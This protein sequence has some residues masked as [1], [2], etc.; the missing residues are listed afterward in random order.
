MTDHFSGAVTAP[1]E[2]AASTK[3]ASLQIQQ[4]TRESKRGGTERRQTRGGEAEGRRG[5]GSS[6]HA[7]KQR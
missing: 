4:E 3:T 1:A 6:L 2:R 5:G 7:G